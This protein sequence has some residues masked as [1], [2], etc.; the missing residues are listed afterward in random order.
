MT[1]IYK[2]IILERLVNPYNT[3]S[4]SIFNDIIFNNT[5]NILLLKNITISGMYSNQDEILII[6]DGVIYR[7][8]C[9]AFS[10]KYN[11][12]KFNNIIVKPNSRL[13][14][15]YVFTPEEKRTT[16]DNEEEENEYLSKYIAGDK[17]IKIGFLFEEFG[18][19]ISKNFQPYFH[20]YFK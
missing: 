13:V 14:L 19:N 6:E 20:I 16:F 15:Q 11:F 12:N 9:P 8:Q 3:I 5:P 18:D 4:F 17:T 2:E 10:I 7:L 1:E